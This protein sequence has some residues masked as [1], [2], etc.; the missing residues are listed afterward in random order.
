VAP[1]DADRRLAL[2][3]SIRKLFFK[4]ASSG[5]QVLRAYRGNLGFAIGWS[6]IALI[7]AG[8]HPFN[9]GLASVAGIGGF[10]AGVVSARGTAERIEKNGGEY[11]A[12]RIRTLIVVGIGLAFGALL[13]YLIFSGALSLN[14][15]LQ[16]YSVYVGLP[17][18]YFGEAVGFEIWEARNEKE[19]HWEG[20]T[21][22]SLPKGLSLQEKYQYR[23]DQW[24][25]LRTRNSGE[26]QA[27]V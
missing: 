1:K 19:I 4:Q 23:A 16:V 14:T 20:R 5:Y 2:R 6:F 7:Q 15:L 18:L 22:Y 21:F 25:R 13:F 24:Y 8:L 27:K 12:S 3:S 9:V 17:A 11:R 10:V 26:Q